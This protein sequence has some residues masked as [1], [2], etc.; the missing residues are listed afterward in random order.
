MSMEQI[1]TWRTELKT[2]QALLEQEFL[3]NTNPASLLKKH[4]KLIDKLLS[5]VWQHSELNNEITLIAVGGY[6]RE[7]LFPFSDMLPMSKTR[8]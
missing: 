5:K 7:E 6:G 3:K 8:K 4:A 1:K 2:Q